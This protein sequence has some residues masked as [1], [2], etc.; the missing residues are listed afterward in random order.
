MK[1]L[2]AQL[3]IGPADKRQEQVRRAERLHDEI[4]P[5]AICSLEF[6]KYRITGF[7]DDDALGT[8]LTAEAL[9]PDL[10]LLIDKLSQSAPL[11]LVD[12]E[13]LETPAQLAARLN[14]STKTISRWR[15]AGL[16]WRWA[17]GTGDD[18]AKIVIPASALARFQHDHADRMRKAAQFTQ[19]SPAAR[20]RILARARRLALACDVS[21]FRV[22]AHLARRV[23][24]SVEGIR[25]LL[26]QHELQHP[27]DPIFPQHTP[28]L[29][30]EQ[31]REIAH[32]RA[33]GVS[34]S[35]LSKRYRRSRASIRRAV[36]EQ[37]AAAV[38]KAEIRFIEAMTFSRDD[39]DVVLLRPE[40]MRA[41]EEP[42]GPL[43]VPCEDLPPQ[44][45][46]LFGRAPLKPE[47]Y[48]ALLAR[49]HY[50]RY[51]AARRRDQ[52]DKYEPRLGD[53]ERIEADLQQAA[54][55]RDR[56][57]VRSLPLVLRVARRHLITLPP[58]ARSLPVLLR[59]LELGLPVTVQAVEQF[60]IRLRKQFE[61]FLRN[62]LMR[63][64]VGK[65]TAAAV[66]LLA[67][68][69][70]QRDSK[71]RARSRLSPQVSGVEVLAHLRA[72]AASLGV[73]LES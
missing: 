23:G 53:I 55:L 36:Y 47:D 8:V 38:R 11:P 57:V 43:I 45:Q 56:L 70:D 59:L 39:A 37:R 13:S 68:H 21:L 40:P 7:R 60:D 3:I 42:I 62:L 1:D 71:P 29:T 20:Q 16:R 14:V 49:M 64:Y 52:L 24:R 67:P 48:P 72:A 33:M 61:D 27:D 50:L 63:H 35:A 30:A 41:L 10:R 2:T 19:L 69:A 26:E 18:Q 25:H 34:V 32:A 46:P 15:Q 5:G 22:A 66:D 73:S 17:R 28:P 51:R 65:E 44:I 58:D 54:H 9:L 6:V 31:K 12:D 4:D